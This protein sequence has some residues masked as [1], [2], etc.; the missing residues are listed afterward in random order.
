MT[1]KK[2]SFDYYELIM[3]R[4]KKDNEI[5][6]LEGRVKKLT[7][8]VEQLLNHITE[9]ERYGLELQREKY[10]TGLTRKIFPI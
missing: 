2:E 3:E 9:H 1:S 10:S 7:A 4:R 5:L 6:V 8:L